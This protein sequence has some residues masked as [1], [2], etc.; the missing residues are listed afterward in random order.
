MFICFLSDRRGLNSEENTIFETGWI[1]ELTFFIYF[2]NLD[3]NIFQIK[4]GVHLYVRQRI[5]L[6]ELTFVFVSL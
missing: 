1:R 4:D 5:F 3:V 6:V 2:V